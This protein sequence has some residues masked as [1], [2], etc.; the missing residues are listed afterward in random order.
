MGLLL[1]KHL[2]WFTFPFFDLCLL[3]HQV[4]AFP[5][6]HQAYSTW[7]FSSIVQLGNFL[8]SSSISFSSWLELHHWSYNGAFLC[9]IHYLFWDSEKGSFW[10]IF[11]WT[12]YLSLTLNYLQYQYLVYSK[13]GSFSHKI[14]KT[15]TYLLK[16]GVL[17]C[18][19]KIKSNN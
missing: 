18:K 7:Y 6:L 15:N 5:P 19:I 4:F 13:Y 8:A 10:C 1:S 3:H 14:L 17:F 16:I 9:C 2:I 11:K 12:V